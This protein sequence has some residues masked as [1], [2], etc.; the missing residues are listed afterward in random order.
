LHERT[1][2]LG[3]DFATPEEAAAY[4]KWLREKVAASL[5]DPRPGIPHREVMGAVQAVI[6]E[7]KARQS[8]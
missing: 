1:I 4:D 7:A 6:D 3:S 8:K 5:A 2:A